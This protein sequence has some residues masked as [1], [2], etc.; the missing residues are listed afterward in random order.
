MQYSIA[1]IKD[2]FEYQQE[3][4]GIEHD[5]KYTEH[6]LIW[7]AIA[8]LRAAVAGTKA[9]MEVAK[10]YHPFADEY[11]K[12]E[13]PRRSLVKAAAFIASELERINAT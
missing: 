4:Y 9:D 12:P 2:E 8:Y 10:S 13:N 3:K 5:S 11:W 7:A 6:E 1:V